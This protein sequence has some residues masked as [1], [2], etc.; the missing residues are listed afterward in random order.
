MT[1]TPRAV[2]RIGRYRVTLP[3]AFLPLL[4]RTEDRVRIRKTPYDRFTF[5][6]V[7]GRLCDVIVAEAVLRHRHDERIVVEVSDQ[8]PHEAFNLDDPEFAS[9]VMEV[10]EKIGKFDGAHR[11]RYAVRPP[12]AAAEL[13]EIPWADVRIVADESEIMLVVRPRD[14]TAPIV[15]T[16]ARLRTAL[17]GYDMERIVLWHGRRY[18]TH[19]PYDE[20]V[21]A[22]KDWGLEVTATNA[23]ASWTLAEANRS[24]SRFL[25]RLSRSLGWRKL[26]AREREACH[27]GADSPQ[28]RNEADLARAYGDLLGYSPTGAGEATLTAA[29]TGHWPEHSEEEE[30]A[31]E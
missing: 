16:F 5:R 27:M 17:E 31:A 29:A 30:Y 18:F 28:W 15:D 7:P 12:P 3:A 22:A 23:A 4:E 13:A 19:L 9:L 14:G 21:Q 6:G 11:R 1:N 24:A 2:T 8:R 20:L 26:T 10:G 25:Y